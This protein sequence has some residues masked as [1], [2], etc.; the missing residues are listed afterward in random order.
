MAQAYIHFSDIA[1]L[2]IGL[3][4]ALFPNWFHKKVWERQRTRLDELEEGA[5]E[6][7]FEERRALETYSPIKKAYV[8]RIIG[9]AMLALCAVRVYNWYTG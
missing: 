5:P 3:P 9:C 6:T 7:Y 1:S 8:F 4:L 2:A